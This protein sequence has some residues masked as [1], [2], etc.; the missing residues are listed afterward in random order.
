MTDVTPR[1]LDWAVNGV[2]VNINRNGAG[3]LYATIHDYS[4]FGV[5]PLATVRVPLA[6]LKTAD[7]AVGHETVKDKLRAFVR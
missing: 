3:E 5:K 6:G 4:R 7:D 1:M 2:P